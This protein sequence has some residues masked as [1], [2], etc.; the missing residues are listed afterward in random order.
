[1][2]YYHGDFV[3]SDINDYHWQLY[4]FFSKY[5]VND[6]STFSI[7]FFAITMQ[8]MRLNQQYS[9]IKLI[10]IQKVDT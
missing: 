7:F 2:F 5:Q 1:M 6:L 9:N 10:K 4:L 3:F 8:V